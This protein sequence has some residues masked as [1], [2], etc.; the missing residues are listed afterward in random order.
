MPG[1]ALAAG[2]R[3]ARGDAPADPQPIPPLLEGGDHVRI[4]SQRAQV[5]WA[6]EL[7]RTPIR[8]DG[9]TQLF[10]SAVPCV[11][12]LWTAFSPVSP[13]VAS[14][15]AQGAKTALVSTQRGKIAKGGIPT[16]E[17]E[18]ELV[19]L[20][21]RANELM[22]GHAMLQHST[23]AAVIAPTTAILDEAAATVESAA[24]TCGLMLR[25]L[26]PRQRA[27][28]GTLIPEVLP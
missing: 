2:A 13:W 15:R 9:L 3:R 27:A 25:R 14:R 8:P 20:Q 17:E 22:G 5:W 28:L 4:G 7:P 12:L 10:A 18:Q 23:F 16:F 21:A 26:G 6:A 24:G 19:D 11:R 1:A